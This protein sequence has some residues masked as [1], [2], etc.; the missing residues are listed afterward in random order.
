MD[1]TNE[2]K[3]HFGEISFVIGN[4]HSFLETSI[5]MKDN[6]IQVDMVEHLEGF[7]GMFGEDFSTLVTSPITKKVF[8]VREDNEKLSEKKG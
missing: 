8:D 1:I 6:K 7:I 2:A 3:K 5:D 4:K